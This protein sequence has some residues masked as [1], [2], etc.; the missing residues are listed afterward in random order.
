MPPHPTSWRSILIL[1]SHLCLG[2]LSGLF[3][4]GFPTKTLH[5]PLPSPT[6]ATCPTYLIL[7]DLINWTILDEEYTAVSSSL[8]SFLYSTVTSSLVGPNIVLST[9][10]QTPSAY[11]P[12][13][14]WDQPSVTP[15][16]NRQNYSSVYLSLCI[17]G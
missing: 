12:S 14:M 17:F 5:T 6:H 2:L 4:W 1:S 11:I 7:L 3:P 8:C 16:H 10:S 13:S 9:Y 15:I